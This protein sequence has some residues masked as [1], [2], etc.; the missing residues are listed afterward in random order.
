MADARS[1]PTEQSLEDSVPTN[2]EMKGMPNS[3]YIIPLV[4]F[5]GRTCPVPILMRWRVVGV[6]I[7]MFIQG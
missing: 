7:G 3:V 6:G 1:E 4:V 5:W 2:R